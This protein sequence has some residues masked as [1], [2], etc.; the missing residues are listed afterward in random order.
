MRPIAAA[1]VESVQ[2]RPL[3]AQPAA[4][5]VA[6]PKPQPVRPQ[7]LQTEPRAVKLPYS[8]E[9]LALL[10]REPKPAAP[11][12]EIALRPATELKPIAVEFVAVEVTQA[13]WPRA[14]ELA[15]AALALW[16]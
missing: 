1:P 8:E 5:P 9:N 10:S 14:V 6:P 12:P 15:P 13:P 2:A 3:P 4:Q 11:R 7:A 16:P